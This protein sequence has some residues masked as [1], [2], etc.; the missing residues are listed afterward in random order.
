M[1]IREIENV[2][3]EKRELRQFGITVAIILGLLG[4]LFFL[5][6]KD[7][8]SYFFIFSG[9]FLLGL[10]TPILLKPIQKIW[11]SLA[12]LIGCF[13]TKVILIV[14][15]YLVITP[16]GLLT[17]VFGKSFLDTKVDRNTDSYWIFR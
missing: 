12:I 17:R 6:E 13:A 8:Y 4:G 15:F 1:I 9:V 10:V 14:L 16:V 5:R 3:S 2:K 11:M 7:H